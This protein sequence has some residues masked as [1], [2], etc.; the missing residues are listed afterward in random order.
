[1]QC[2]LLLLVALMQ[3]A[4]PARPQPPPPRPSDDVVRLRREADAFGAAGRHLEAVAALREATTRAP[5][6]PSGW[7]A[8]GLAYN[9]IKDEAIRTFDVAREEMPWRQLLGA[10]AQASR[11]QW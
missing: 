3:A 8:L 7:Y 5:K 10:D 6:V 1:M 2:A 9:A 4:P 11:G